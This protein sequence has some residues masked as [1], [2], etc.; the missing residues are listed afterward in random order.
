MCSSM[1][2]A[3]ADENS[4]DV[5]INLLVEKFLKWYMNETSEI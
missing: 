3:L 2:D 5:A 1:R 4:C